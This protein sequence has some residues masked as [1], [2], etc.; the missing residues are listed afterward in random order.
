LKLGQALGAAL[1]ATFGGGARLYEY[2]PREVK[3]G[4]VGSGGAEKRQVQR[5]V[6]LLLA[7]EGALG[8]DAADALAIALCHAHGRATRL[9][10]DAASARGAA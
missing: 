1:C 10:L 9:A 2:S 8:A 3:L 4:V 6:R 5:M 7:L